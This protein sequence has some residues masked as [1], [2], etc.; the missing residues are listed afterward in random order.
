VV[1]GT[2]GAAVSIPAGATDDD[3][4]ISV[5]PIDTLAGLP[6]TGD[7]GAFAGGIEL[8]P[9]GMVFA[10]PVTITIPLTQPQTPG[11]ELRLFYWDGSGSAWEE[12]DSTARVA[13]DGRTA[14]GEVGHFSYYVLQPSQVEAEADGIFGDINGVVVTLTKGGEDLATATEAVFD[15]V[16]GHVNARFPFGKPRPLDIPIPNGYN[17]YEPVGLY[18]QFDHGGAPGIPRPLV[19]TIGDIDNVEFRIDY[20]REVDVNVVAGDVQNQVVGLFTVNVYWR[21]RPPVLRLTPRD[22]ALWAGESTRLDADLFCGDLGMRDQGITLSVIPGSAS[23]SVSPEEVKTDRVGRG[24]ATLTAA[25][26]ATGS[27]VVAARHAWSSQ[28]GDVKADVGV[29]TRV[30][31]GSITGT[32]TVSGS[33]TW[34]GCMDPGDNGTYTGKVKV[35][36][37]Q[38]GETVTGSGWARPAEDLIS[39]D[40]VFAGTVE[41]IGKRAFTVTG[42]S[43]YVE[44]YRVCTPEGCRTVTVRGYTEFDGTGS[45]GSDKIAFTWNGRDL[46]G[47]TCVIAGR[48]TAT[49]RGP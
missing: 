46:K 34:S 28:K 17:C 35:R 24:S 37:D 29:T 33:E 26:D 18:F 27:V 19:A 47:D 6:V 25:D 8:L 4:A 9:H 36:F 45:L 49:Y 14:S 15:E 7:P 5:R 1:T 16:I 30:R 22:A 44:K 32:W 42:T 41:R 2:G 21:S 43:N 10:V 20:L 12:T 11:R 3:R 23:A 38:L 31:V 13:A 40:D 48:G 39:G